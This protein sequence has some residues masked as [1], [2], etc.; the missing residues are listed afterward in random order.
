MLPVSKPLEYRVQQL[1]AE[2]SRL[3]AELELAR[4][5]LPTASC[6]TPLTVDP[7]SGA[8]L[9]R[10]YLYPVDA[11]TG[12]FA[13][14]AGLKRFSMD[15]GFNEGHVMVGDWL[16]WKPDTFG[17]GIEANP[18]LYALFD[19]ITTE[20]TWPQ[21]FEGYHWT[22]S[23]DSSVARAR[24]FKAASA[25]GQLLLVHAAVTTS[26]K[27]TMPF[28][29]G[30]GWRT[31]GTLI[32]DVGSLYNFGDPVRKR[33]QQSMHVA[34]LRL[35]DILAHVPPPPASLGTPSS[36]GRNEV[37]TLIWDTLKIDVQGADIEALESAGPY[38]ER[39]Y[40]IIG[41]FAARHYDIPIVHGGQKALAAD[42]LTRS[43]F[44]MARATPHNQLWLN[45]RYRAHFAAAD[46]KLRNYT[47]ITGGF[48]G[49]NGVQPDSYF[50]RWQ[51]Q[52]MFAN[53]AQKMIEEA[54]ACQTK[55]EC[56]PGVAAGGL[57]KV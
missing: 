7:V 1:T 16:R 57:L 49:G 3:R 14:P 13:V 38:L 20:K 12:L 31:D 23:N 40:C 51:K 10:R 4:K 36:P 15:V 25:R 52:P 32:P 30:F 28:N 21:G 50:E 53:T 47:C 18:Y 11:A 54:A 17:I 55:N 37:N 5:A 19:I 2:V 9:Q 56:A 8:M 27:R 39:F 46:P 24:K 48:N 43:G 41:E 33:A 29:L 44:V 42:I 45:R 22:A 34:T 6:N 35:D 26:T